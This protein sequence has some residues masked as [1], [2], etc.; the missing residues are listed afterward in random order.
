MPA[1]LVPTTRT[2]YTTAQ[3]IAGYV[4]G[5]KQQF[6]ELPSKEAIGVLYAQNTLE[7][8]GTTSMWNNNLGNV[9][10]VASSNPDNDNGKLYM[11]LANVWEIV[12]GQKVIFQPPSPATWFRAFA[13]LADGVAFELDF[14]KNHRYSK[15]WS[16]VEAGNPA[17]FAHLLKLAGYYTAPEADYVKLMNFYFG[18]YMK[19]TAYEDAV[20]ALNP[21]APEPD[22]I[23]EPVPVAPEPPPAPVPDPVPAPAPTPPPAAPTSLLTNILNTIFNL[24]KRK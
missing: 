19:T 5:W 13:T 6:G 8:G 24:F 2:S 10:F 9:K 11:M 22:P 15:A 16:A 12:N 17:A 4:A 18:K 14:L 23:P 20:N 1:T 21:P 3:L 7:T